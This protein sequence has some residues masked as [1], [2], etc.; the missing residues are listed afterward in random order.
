MSGLNRP[1]LTE[2]LDLRDRAA[3]VW[4]FLADCDSEETFGFRV[5]PDYEILWEQIPNSPGA[6]AHLDYDR[7]IRLHRA[8][9]ALG[10]ESRMRRAAKGDVECKWAGGNAF[11]GECAGWIEP[12]RRVVSNADW[13]AQV[14]AWL[15]LAES[16]IEEGCPE[17]CD[18]GV[19]D[20]CPG[21]LPDQIA[22]S[23]YSQGN[24]FYDGLACAGE[25][26]ETQ[27]FRISP[28]DLPVILTRD[29][30]CEWEGAAT[31]ERS[32]NGGAWEE[33]V[34]DASILLTLGALAWEITIDTLR[35]MEKPSGLSPLGGYT[36][37][38]CNEEET[39]SI[40][41]RSI[42]VIE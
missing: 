38:F 28:D 36:A 34:A 12:Q 35:T 17:K 31:V 29:G 7:L 20:D 24:V 6:Q 40:S 5:C 8:M 23:F 13:V 39:T 16:W 41:E 19:P 3:A 21:D 42:A 32:V 37:N 10:A 2:F 27:Y 11:D 4:Q 22:L 9:V 15:A 30:G 14:E 26:T 1:T 18:D 25:A 33:F